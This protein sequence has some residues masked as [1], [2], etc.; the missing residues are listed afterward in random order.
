[1]KEGFYS[2]MDRFLSLPP[3][4]QEIG[5]IFNK[6]GYRLYVV[7]GY[8]RNSL[9]KLPVT[10]CDICSA[11]KPEEA[12]GFLRAMGF[13]VIEKAPKFGTI[14]IHVQLNGANHILEHTTF[15]RDFYAPGGAHRPEHVDFT[16]DIHMDAVRRDFTVNALYADAVTGEVKD[17]LGRSMSD[18]DKGVIA[19]AHKDPYETLKDDG[20]RLMRLVRF[21]SELGFSVDPLLMKAAAR[22]SGLLK[23]ISKE[24]IQAELVKIALCDIKYPSLKLKAPHK[25]GMLLLDELKLLP[26]ILPSLEECKNIPQN[27]KYH[28]YDVFLH[29]VEAFAASPPD[30]CVRL[31]ALLHDTGKPAAL[32]TQGNM[33]GHEKTGAALA[34]REL[35]ALRFDNRTIKTVSLLIY[36]HMF[37]LDNRAKPSTVRKKA[38]KIGKEAFS[39]LIALRRADFIGSGKS[40]E[41]VA[42]ADKWQNVLMEMVKE[43]TPFTVNELNLSG[44]EI[45]RELGLE[46]GAVIG[47]IKEALL[48]LCLQKPSQNN[49]ENLLAHARSVY[50]SMQGKQ[51]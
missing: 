14:E 23:D 44:A 48:K 22:H 51:K 3:V 16:G 34:S 38:A 37:D 33:Y 32:R 4:L 31:S 49:R 29:C 36:H 19:A 25:K 15:R 13:R 24:R 42:S 20:L 43:N 17:V 39:K 5:G 1:M 21:C 2:K 28:A 50:R 30:L 47:D 12:A 9:L 10:D 35:K 46:S 7:G 26:Y 41:S 27:H 40:V 18:L 45:M 11:A 6:K 8:V